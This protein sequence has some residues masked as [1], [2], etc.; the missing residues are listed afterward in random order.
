MKDEVELQVN[1]LTTKLGKIVFDHDPGIAMQAIVNNIRLQLVR[2]KPE[3]KHALALAIIQ[4]VTNCI[5]L[6]D[7]KE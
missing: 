7:I 3:H 6:S 5:D 4:D 1:K 2:V